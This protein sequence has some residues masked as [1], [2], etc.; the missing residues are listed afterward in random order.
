[1]EIHRYQGLLVLKSIKCKNIFIKMP[2][3]DKNYHSFVEILIKIYDFM[4]V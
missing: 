3:V 4:R 2:K 1:M